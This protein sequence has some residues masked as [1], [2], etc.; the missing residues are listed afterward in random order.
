MVFLPGIPSTRRFAK[1]QN[2][3]SNRMR[4]VSTDTFRL[5]RLVSPQGTTAAAQGRGEKGRRWRRIGLCYRGGREEA[6]G[7]GP[8]PS[9]RKQREISIY[10]CAGG[11]WTGPK[12]AAINP[13]WF[14]LFGLVFVNRP[15][16]SLLFRQTKDSGCLWEA[17]VKDD[18]THK[19]TELP[20]HS[21]PWSGLFRGQGAVGPKAAG[22]DGGIRTLKVLTDRGS[23][24]SAAAHQGKPWPLC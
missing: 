18:L 6:A 14:Y 22:L 8:T 10:V 15:Q 11:C 19:S 12:A 7:F 20:A 1:A 13:P 16:K 17:S 5:P 2:L 4:R 3:Q 23:T 24:P 21:Y 9:H